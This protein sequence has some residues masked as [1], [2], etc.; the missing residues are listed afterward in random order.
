MLDDTISPDHEQIILLYARAEELIGRKLPPK[1]RHA[2]ALAFARSNA[3]CSADQVDAALDLLRRDTDLRCSNMS[4]FPVS[5]ELASAPRG[6]DPQ[7]DCD[8]DRFRRS[9]YDVG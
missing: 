9:P 7:V 4:G 3:C 8:A 1:E 6:V 5:F 2:A